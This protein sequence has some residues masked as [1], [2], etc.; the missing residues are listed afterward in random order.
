MNLRAAFTFLSAFLLLPAG[1]ALS[2]ARAQNAYCDELRARLNEAGQAPQAVRQRADAAKQRGELGAL[3]ARARAMGCERAQ[4]LFFGDPPPPQCGSLNARIA[5]MRARLAALEQGEGSNLKA[6]LM[7]RYD[8]RCRR[9]PVARP[10]NFFEEL[11]GVP[12]APGWGGSGEA[13][14]A[15]PPPLEPEEAR[16]SGGSMAICVRR[17]DGAFFPVSY[18]AGAS[19]LSELSEL[20]Q[21]LCPNAETTLYTRSPWRDIETAVSIDGEPYADH[22]NALKFQKTFDPSCACKSPDKS[23]AETLAEAERLLAGRH[24]GDAVVTAER[25]AELSRP[26]SA[27]KKGALPASAAKPAVPAGSPGAT[28]EV[29]GADGIKKRVRV[30]APEL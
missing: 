27:G 10:R 2:P 26:S 9:R 19:R 3:A 18:S 11:F 21:A 24:G 13:P 30:I 14:A 22:P 15:P 28:R 6:A 20:C 1:A 29:T 23:W 8:A 12:Q 17:C 4:F 16:P 25:A 7:A 5:Q